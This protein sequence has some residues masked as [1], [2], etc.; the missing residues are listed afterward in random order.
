MEKALTPL[1]LPWLG[2]QVAAL[3]E[4]RRAEGSGNTPATA[5]RQEEAEQRVAAAL[6][7]GRAML[8]CA[9]G[10]A[11]FLASGNLAASFTT[12]VVCQLASASVMGLA[13]QGEQDPPRG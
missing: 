5:S 1:P 12:G 8:G 10:Y 4:Q 6:L 9:A 13:A 7:G 3:Q 2:I 11:A